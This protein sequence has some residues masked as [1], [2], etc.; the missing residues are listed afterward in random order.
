MLF[1]SQ[2]QKILDNL[3]KNAR[4]DVSGRREQL[5]QDLQEIEGILEISN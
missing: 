3:G 5:L 1:R 4:Q 2:K